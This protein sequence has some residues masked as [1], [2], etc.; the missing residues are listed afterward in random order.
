[1]YSK[2]VLYVMGDF[3]MNIELFIHAMLSYYVVFLCF[4]MQLMKSMYFCL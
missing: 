4:L 3:I 2:D 1:M